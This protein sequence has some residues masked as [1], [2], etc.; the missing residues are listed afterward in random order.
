MDAVII[1]MTLHT[2]TAHRLCEFMLGD[3]AAEC[4]KQ[5]SNHFCKNPLY[6]IM[7]N[8][9]IIAYHILT[10]HSFTIYFCFFANSANTL[11]YNNA[12]A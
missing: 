1:H 4:L 5:S 6:V 9:F 10:G 2:H 7:M 11:Q 8:V 3:T 12:K